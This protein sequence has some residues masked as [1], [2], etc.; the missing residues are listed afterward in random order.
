M[1][2]YLFLSFFLLLGLVK[3]QAQSNLSLAV[4]AQVQL[5][6]GLNTLDV[7]LEN[8]DSKD[9]NGSLTLG[10]PK[11]LT[12]ILGEHIP[13]KV[14]AGKK[15]FLSL[16]LQSVALSGLKNKQLRIS[17]LNDENQSLQERLIAIEVPEKR[18]VTIN[19]NT[20]LQYFRQVGDSVYVKISVT[21]NGTT[22]EDINILFSSPD[23]IG[24][25]NF[26]AVPLHLLSGQDTVLQLSIVVEK[27]MMALAQ[28]TVR[29]SGIYDNSDVFGNSSILFSNIASNRDFQ[30]MFRMDNDLAIY[31]RNFV[32]LQLN[33]AF[34]NRRMYYLRSEGGY[35]MGD[36]KLNYG[37]NLTQFGD[38]KSNPN[39]NSTFLS[40]EGDQFQA[41]LG[42]IQ[43][44]IEAP[45][46]GRG[47]KAAIWNEERTHKLSAGFVEKS[48][49][50]LGFYSDRSPGY[51]AFSRLSIGEQDNGRKQYE[52]QAFFDKDQL[53]STQSILLANFFDLMP[54]DYTKDMQLTAFVGSGLNQSYTNGNV[55][56]SGALG[57]KWSGRSQAWTYSSDN[58]VSSAYYPGNRR[59]TTQL[60]QRLGRSIAKGY[61]SLGYYYSAYEPAY[62]N[63]NFISFQSNSS[64][65]DLNINLPVSNF[66]TWNIQPSL[67]YETGTYWLDA[68]PLALSIR[69]WQLLNTINLRSKNYQHSVFLTTETG[70]ISLADKLQNE[71]VF[72]GN[73]SYTFKAF[74]LFGSY[75]RGAF[76]VYELVNSAL[77]NQNVGDRYAVG[78]SYSA[79]LLKSKL[80]WGAGVMGNFSGIFGN[81]YAANLNANYRVL[82][83]TLLTSSFQYS[84]NKTNSGADYV[85]TNMRIGVRQNL[86]S[87]NLDR[88]VEK[89][90]TL[91]VFCFYDNNNN[92]E[93]D[94][95]DEVAQEYN[96]M[97]RNVLFITDRKGQASFK[98]MPYGEYMLFFPM[99]N[100]YQA[101]SKL[102]AVNRS[103]VAIEV[104]LQKIGLVSGRI[105]IDYDV[106]LSVE[107]DLRMHDYRVIAIDE[108]GRA[109]E[110]ISN[111][112]GEF[113]FSLPQGSYSFS[114]DSQS[115]PANIS[116]LDNQR[117]GLVEIGKTL[118]LTPFVLQVKEKNIEVKRF[119]SR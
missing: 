59:G 68:N 109:F 73:F 2:L 45:I 47:I 107:A 105:T 66:F 102:L 115:F 72:K 55:K 19:D 9:F 4:T 100:G 65:L 38:F 92:G 70:L 5:N 14:L 13:V 27:Y 23:R 74:S 43:E 76:Q 36:G 77:L 44:N 6:P 108:Q 25:R 89:T 82:K 81:A 56:P 87:Q 67:N 112:Y 61:Y 3:G 29:V 34:D 90:G 106:N 96:F 60:M 26:K 28:Y 113:E 15:R 33:N 94:A 86:K 111:K 80:S 57:L 97:V 99:R 93:Y 20:Q 103:S 35:R 62:L 10:L 40:Y 1:R 37:L 110:A 64:K 24:D 85:F 79:G 50:L 53:D 48:N 41:T 17:L 11:G 114:L 52:G 88:A 63:Q 95:G 8:K 118:D 91:K 116:V 78:S 51:T 69:S 54:V 101:V 84:Y 21:N 83:N 71:F 7:V 32:D 42:N 22:D 16:K 58:F 30:R 31:S 75:Q 104:P 49:D 119:G 18:S 98:K 39:L 117:S 46:Y 12:S